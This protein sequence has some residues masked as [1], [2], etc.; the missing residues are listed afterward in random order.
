MD[1]AAFLKVKTCDADN[2]EVWNREP[3]AARR[4]KINVKILYLSI[5]STNAPKRKMFQ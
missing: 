1:R 3:V 2:K 4:H 5:K